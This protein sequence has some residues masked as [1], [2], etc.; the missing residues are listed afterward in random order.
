MQMQRLKCDYSVLGEV[1]KNIQLRNFISGEFIVDTINNDL[2]ETVNIYLIK[3]KV[4]K[5]DQ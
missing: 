4:T 5:K 2:G 3:K 1:L